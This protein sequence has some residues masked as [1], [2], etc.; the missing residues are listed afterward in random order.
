[1]PLFQWPGVSLNRDFAV[2][3]EDVVAENQTINDVHRRLSRGT[4]VMPDRRASLKFCM[5]TRVRPR[6]SSLSPLCRLELPCELSFNARTLADVFTWRLGHACRVVAWVL[7]SFVGSEPDTN[8]AWWNWRWHW[9]LV[10]CVE[11]V[12]SA[13][14][15]HGSFF[16]SWWASAKTQLNYTFS[17]WFEFL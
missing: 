11:D 12:C 13:A 6:P 8:S 7:G 4:N 16:D 5:F 3:S 2:R 10:R 15:W 9:D 1:M 14:D 17:K